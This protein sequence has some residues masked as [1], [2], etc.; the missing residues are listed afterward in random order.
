M[1]SSYL[2]EKSFSAWFVKEFVKVL[3]RVIN[4][5]SKSEENKRIVKWL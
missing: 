4:V 3:M 2:N 5:V 1:F